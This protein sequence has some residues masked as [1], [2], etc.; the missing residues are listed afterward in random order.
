MRL[1]QHPDRFDVMHQLQQM[2]PRAQAH[3]IYRTSVMLEFPWEMRFGLNLAFYRPFAVPRIAAVIA[4]TGE[5]THQPRKRAIDTGL[6]MYELIE[7]G[8]EDP[9]GREVVRGLNRMHR[10]LEIVNEDYLYVLASFVI[11]PTRWIEG[12]GWRE[13]TDVEREAAA[14]FY[15]ELGRH[16]AITDL[17]EDYQGFAQFFDAYERAH[18]AHSTAGAAQMSA[19]QAIIDEQLPRRL[20]RLGAPAI[21]ALLDDRLTSALGV[22]SGNPVLRQ[23]VRAVLAARR[24]AVRRQPPRTA[25]WF[26]PGRRIRGLYPDGYQLD[27]LGPDSARTPLPVED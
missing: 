21:S 19:T 23:V 15:R 3:Q 9:R 20:Q 24:V 7:H 12:H 5:M 8:F 11:V 10:R 2:D 6:W 14:A 17:P 22:R 26:E 27:H 1:R 4:G 16:M 25:P 13:I 18:V